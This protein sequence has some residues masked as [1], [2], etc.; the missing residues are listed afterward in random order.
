MKIKRKCEVCK[1]DFIAIKTT[2]KYCSRRCFK[3]NYYLKAKAK[4][5]YEL[6]H[7]IYPK[8]ICSYCNQETTLTFDPIIFP[9]LFN[10]FTCSNCGVTAELILR[11]A[12]TPNSFQKITDEIINISSFQTVGTITMQISV[13][14]FSTDGG[15]T[16]HH[17]METTYDVSP[18]S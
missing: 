16:E 13:S 1:T 12:N 3:R 17:S 9:K 5:Q 2:Q 14:T 18:S 11:H 15:Q 4:Q 7:P 8:K 10:N 6:K